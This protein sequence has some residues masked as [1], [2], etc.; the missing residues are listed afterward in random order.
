MTERGCV[1][2]SQAE[3]SVSEEVGMASA[4]SLVGQRFRSL[5]SWVALRGDRAL[6]NESAA[7]RARG[8]WRELTRRKLLPDRTTHQHEEVVDGFVAFEGFSDG[9]IAG[10]FSHEVA[11]AFVHEHLQSAAIGDHFGPSFDD[12]LLGGR[13]HEVVDDARATLGPVCFGGGDVGHVGD[14]VAW[15]DE[16]T[17]EAFVVA[18]ENRASVLGA[19]EALLKSRK[20]G[21]GVL[22][23]EDDFYSGC[24][25]GGHEIVER[26]WSVYCELEEASLVLSSEGHAGGQTRVKVEGFQVA[27]DLFD[28]RVGV[29]ELLS[30]AGNS[31]WDLA[32]ASPP[33]Q[34]DF[35]WLVEGCRPRYAG[36]ASMYTRVVWWSFSA[37]D[38]MVGFAVN[39][40]KEK[41][42]K[43]KNKRRCRI[44]PRHIAGLRQV[45]VLVF[46]DK[47]P[48]NGLG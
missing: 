45:L 4:F 16:L 9:H 20:D 48:M 10:D 15:A 35:G 28:G 46:L 43:V 41:L 21:E 3:H 8:R 5:D 37:T 29:F 11:G 36:G 39:G 2:L 42:Q 33:A 18:I 34:D 17:G 25:V 12:V 31:F 6:K 40:S 7:L 22:P 14:E 1:N 24:D 38:S 47:G 30:Q 27:L 13:N 23:F 19:A 44:Y 32:H 26:A